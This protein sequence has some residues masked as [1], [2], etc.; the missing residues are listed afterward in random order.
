MCCPACAAASRSARKSP[1]RPAPSSSSS[2]TTTAARR[3]STCRRSDGPG[4][5][6]FAMHG[7]R[8]LVVLALGA[9]L[10]MSGALAQ[11]PEGAGLQLRVA[12]ELAAVTPPVH[13]VL[14]L[15]ATRH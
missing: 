3:P 8:L 13:H 1:F 5:A 4:P 7:T 6:S 15:G 9:G 10:T 11:A 12:P 14:S 2:C